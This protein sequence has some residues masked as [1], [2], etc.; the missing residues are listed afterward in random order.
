MFENDEEEVRAL[1]ILVMEDYEERGGI[2]EGND[3]HVPGQTG[4]V[5]SVLD[6]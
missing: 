3:P 6:R 1:L 2:P 4:Q 5:Q